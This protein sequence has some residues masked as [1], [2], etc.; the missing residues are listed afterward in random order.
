MC[1]SIYE[2]GI[3]STH[4][5]TLK[6]KRRDNV[7]KFHFL[8]SIKRP[9]IETSSWQQLLVL[10]GVYWIDPDW[11]SHGNALEASCNFTLRQMCVKCLN[12]ERINNDEEAS[13]L[14]LQFTS[15]VTEP[16]SRLGF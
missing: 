12:S 11:G 10:L 9:P 14:I 5:N 3:S 4:H 7:H 13:Y 16:F 8:L 6:R 1:I 2:I 15:N